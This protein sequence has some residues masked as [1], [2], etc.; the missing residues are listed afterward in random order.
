M[1][2]SSA[3]I[4]LVS[5]FTV[6]GTTGFTVAKFNYLSAVAKETLDA[7]DPGLTSALYDHA[8]ALLICHLYDA[9]NLGKGAYTSERIG[10]YG[11]SKA[12]GT[13]PYYE[14]YRRIIDNAIIAS[15]PAAS[16]EVERTDHKMN[17]LKLDAN[18]IPEYGRDEEGT[19]Q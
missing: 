17:V 8:H 7:E 13:S 3:T 11:Y 15:V 1:V 18:P 9:Q 5:P 19:E 2:A 4:A 14:Q 16:A 6:G 10:D 12:A